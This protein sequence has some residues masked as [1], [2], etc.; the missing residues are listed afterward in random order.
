MF[1]LH[2]MKSLYP[3]SPTCS[4]YLVNVKEFQSTL[5]YKNILSFNNGFRK[6]KWAS[7]NEAEQKG[8]SV[9]KKII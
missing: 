9:I 5:T 1:C 4:S 8:V 7:A 6:T 3:N 2:M